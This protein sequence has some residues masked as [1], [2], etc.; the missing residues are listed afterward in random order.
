MSVATAIE[1]IL[2]LP[3]DAFKADRRATFIGR[4]A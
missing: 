3:G 1:A 2:A 4:R